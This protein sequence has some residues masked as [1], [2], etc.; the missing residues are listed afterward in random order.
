MSPLVLKLVRKP[1]SMAEPIESKEQK[2]ISEQVSANDHQRELISGRYFKTNNP[3]GPPMVRIYV[4]TEKTLWVLPEDLLCDR[5]KF[6]DSAFRSGFR[7][8]N[9]KALE[10]LGEDPVAFEYILDY[11]LEKFTDPEVI[12]KLE[13]LEAIHT[14]WFRTWILADMIGCVGV[15]PRIRAHYNEYL[16][17]KTLEQ[18]MFPP[19]VV[20][21]LYENTSVS[22]NRVLFTFCVMSGS[23]CIIVPKLLE[24]SALGNK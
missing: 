15:L 20:R 13:D 8:G 16:S 21:V 14:T 9:K 6:F 4:G 24:H 7:E 12:N 3:A 2:R 19:N 1:T 22:L 11:I 23:L 17:C 5:L 10:L 18:R